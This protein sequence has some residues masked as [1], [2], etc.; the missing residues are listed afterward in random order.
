MNKIFNQVMGFGTRQPKESTPRIKGKGIQFDK[1][2]ADAQ[3]KGLRLYADDLC[4]C[5]WIWKDG[6]TIDGTHDPFSRLSEVATF[7][8]SYTV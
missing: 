4:K 8:K 2:S 5:Y 6:N 1:L 7:L 3:S